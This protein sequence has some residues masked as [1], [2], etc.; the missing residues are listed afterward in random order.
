MNH[1]RRTRSAAPLRATRASDVP[2]PHRG[3]WL[4]EDDRCIRPARRPPH[5]STT[6]RERQGAW[7]AVRGTSG[8]T[9]TPERCDDHS[10]RAS[11]VA[12]W[13]RGADDGERI[14][15]RIRRRVDRRCRSADHGRPQPSPLLWPDHAAG[16]PP[17]LRGSDSAKPV[18]PRDAGRAD[19]TRTARRNHVWSESCR[20]RKRPPSPWA[21]GDYRPATSDART[22]HHSGQ[23]FE[24]TESSSR[25]IPG[26]RN[27]NND[28]AIAKR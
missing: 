16:S 1:R 17:R 12:P 3:S 27:A 14:R 28:Q 18:R 9:P 11:A 26:T 25:V 15:L 4:R 21:R 8:T 7:P 23:L 20:R 2:S 6:P 13:C 10:Q 5:R 22:V 19:A 24:T